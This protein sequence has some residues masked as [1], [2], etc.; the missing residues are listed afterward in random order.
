MLWGSYYGQNRLYHPQILKMGHF[1][2]LYNNYKITVCRIR[3]EFRTESQSRCVDRNDQR[4]AAMLHTA[5][6]EH[7]ATTTHAARIEH[8]HRAP[9]IE[10]LRHATHR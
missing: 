2:G 5:N 7:K 8:H 9:R 6:G 4:M 10:S 1:V 3:L